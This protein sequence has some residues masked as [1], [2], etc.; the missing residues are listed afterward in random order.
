MYVVH[1]GVVNMWEL[2]SATCMGV[3]QVLHCNVH[4]K[5]WALKWIQTQL[6]TDFNACAQHVQ[7]SD[8]TCPKILLTYFLWLEH[9]FRTQC[10]TAHLPRLHS[11]LMQTLNPLLCWFHKNQCSG[12]CVLICR[13]KSAPH[14]CKHAW[15]LLWTQ[16]MVLIIV[17][18]KETG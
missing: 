7:A 18:P 1:T 12:S 3:S 5:L 8:V 11:S 6:G 14:I 16:W 10:V 9:V 17:T 2:H 4:V 13:D 15:K